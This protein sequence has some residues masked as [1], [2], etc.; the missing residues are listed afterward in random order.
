MT[1]IPVTTTDDELANMAERGELTPL[2]P[3]S[4]PVHFESAEELAQFITNAHPGGRPN[5]GANHAT[6]EGRS[7]RRQVRLPRDL[8]VRLDDFAKAQAVTPSD[9]I[10]DA[11]T[12]YLNTH[13]LRA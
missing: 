12:D 3:P 5:L 8:N 1:R 9:V 4:G 7:P 2:G 13:E 11:L 6:G 10:R